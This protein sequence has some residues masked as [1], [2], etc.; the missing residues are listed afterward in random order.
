MSDDLNEEE[1]LGKVYDSRLI[2]LLWPFIKP[3]RW[4]VVV[5]LL[6]VFPLFATQA[7]PAWIIAAGLDYTFVNDSREVAAMIQ[8]EASSWWHRA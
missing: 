6:M 1:D 3:Y 5:T 8:A 7:L 4:Q 2:K